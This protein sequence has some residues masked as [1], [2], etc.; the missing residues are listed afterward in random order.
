MIFN[1]YSQEIPTYLWV[2]K[3]YVASQF[4]TMTIPFIH[5][6]C[7]LAQAQFSQIPH[8]PIGTFSLQISI[9]LSSHQIYQTDNGKW[10]WTQRMN[11]N[12]KNNEYC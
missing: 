5:V 10:K 7:G 2:Y 12:K 11:Q 1:E 9:F 3:D 4:P 8:G 6:I